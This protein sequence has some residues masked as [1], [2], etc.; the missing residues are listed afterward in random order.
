LSRGQSKY[1]EPNSYWKPPD[2]WEDQG[3]SSENTLYQS[4]GRALSS[5]AHVEFI[6]GFAFGTFIETNWGA[7]GRVYGSIEGTKGRIA[8][9]KAV[10][11][12]AFYLKKVSEQERVDWARLLVHYDRGSGVRNEIA[13]GAAVHVSNNHGNLGWFLVPAFD[14]PKKNNLV[15]KAMDSG[16]MPLGRQ[17]YRFTS[18][19]IDAIA[20]KFFDLTCWVQAFDHQYSLKYPRKQ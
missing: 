4:V 6:F 2:K 9:L 8:A 3:D 17:K 15:W 12:D 5:W 10:T 16:E 19:N 20:Q 11:D 13:H 14:N 1:P 7:I 18:A